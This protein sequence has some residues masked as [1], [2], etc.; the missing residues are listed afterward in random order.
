MTDPH[1]FDAGIAL[2]WQ[3]EVARGRTLPM[4][5]NFIGPFGGLTA[6][7]AM[8]AVL[9][10]PQRLGDP[11]SLTVNFAAAL[12]DGPFDV[13][14]KPARTNRSTQHWIIT[15]E[16]GGEVVTTA[17]ALT[18]VRRETWSAKEAQAPEVPRPADVPI[19]KAPPR[20]EWVKRYDMR[21]I[22]GSLTGEWHGGD[23]GHSRTRLWVRDNPPRP[24]DFTSLTAMSD[25]FFP[26]IWLR[27][28]TFVPL[29]TITMT[30][31]F[32]ATEAQLRETGTGY[33]LGQTQGQGFGAGYFDHTAQLWNEAGTL[34]ATT[35][36][37][38]YFKE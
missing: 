35:S 7:Q 14:A 29:G 2:E 23:A 31:Y 37:V 15:I 20:V 26:R 16:Q 27:R 11:V 32:H 10:H 33:L 38:Y 30:T 18:A 24:L 4:W 21:F 3:G 19:P 12:Q 5:S 25:I 22:D 34:L 9:Q 17:T 36:Q 8:A 13:I 6:A 1:P 28:A